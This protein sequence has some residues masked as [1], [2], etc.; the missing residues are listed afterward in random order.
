MQQI[1]HSIVRIIIINSKTE[2]ITTFS[3]L[4]ETRFLGSKNEWYIKIIKKKLNIVFLNIL[5]I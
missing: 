2:K 4:D 3:I 5:N 1:E